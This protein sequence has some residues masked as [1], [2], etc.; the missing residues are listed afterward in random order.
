MADL[1]LSSCFAKVFAETANLNFDSFY[2][3]V[4]EYFR[5]NE[6]FFSSKSINLF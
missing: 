6:L 4:Q 1:K 5:K 2:K 3:G